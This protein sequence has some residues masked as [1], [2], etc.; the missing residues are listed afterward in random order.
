MAVTTIEC[1]PWRRVGPSPDCAC[2]LTAQTL[3]AAGHDPGPGRGLLRI[4]SVGL[5]SNEKPICQVHSCV[6]YSPDPVPPPLSPTPGSG[7]ACP[8]RLARAST[9]RNLA[10][11]SRPSHSVRVGPALGPPIPPSA[12]HSPTHPSRKTR[13]GERRRGAPPAGVPGNQRDSEAVRPG[14]A[15]RP[16]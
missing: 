16:T 3:A 12:G 1:G 10:R 8:R 7:R 15:R 5:F 2:L 11:P 9:G 4:D 14:A 13:Q 6:G